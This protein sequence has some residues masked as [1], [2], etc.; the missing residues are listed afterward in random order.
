MFVAILWQE[1]EGE[2]MGMRVHDV[3]KHSIDMSLE[4]APIV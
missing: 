1:L 2:R 3:E 4:A